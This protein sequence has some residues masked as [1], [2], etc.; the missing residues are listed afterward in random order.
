[1]RKIRVLVIDAFDIA[2]L[3]NEYLHEIDLI[4]QPEIAPQEV[5]TFLNDVDILVLKSKISIG[6]EIVAL[7]PQLKYIIRGGAGLDHIRKEDLNQ[8]GIQVIATP[9]GNRHAVG[10][11]TIGL[12]LALL[13]KTIP[14]YRQIGGGNWLRKPFT[15]T[16]LRNKTLGIIGYGNT[17]SAVAE[18][19]AAFGMQVLAYDKYKSGFST[20]NL[21]EA[22]MT[23][24]FRY[25]DILTL[26]VPLDASTRYLVNAEYIANF[27]KN[28]WLLNL[29][30][31][32]VV[33]TEA[34]IQALKVGKI[35]GAALDVLENEDFDSLTD[36]EKETLNQ[37]L[38]M[39]NII[40]TPHIG[41]LTEESFSD[42]TSMVGIAITEA[43][44]SIQNSSNSQIV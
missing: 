35:K 15:G 27:Q 13:R 12:L 34:L 23:D 24:I 19:I 26:H 20:A 25:A 41:G 38:G 29:S 42:I 16:E 10:E 22:N 9:G 6:S 14:A 40:L 36:L 33:H 21:Q 2:L 7:A 37:L 3:K 39:E 18:K 4:Y 17:G 8:H 44:K 43:V 28:F 11:H 1:M 31:G 5:R 30:R 32:G